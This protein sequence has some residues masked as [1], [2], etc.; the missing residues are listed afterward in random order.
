MEDHRVTDT[1]SFNRHL[2]YA[3]ISE[4]DHI[5]KDTVIICFGAGGTK[6]PTAEKS[7]QHKTVVTHMFDN[8]LSDII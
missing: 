8:V 6:A 5:R 2:I 4:T 3:I 7:K 1:V